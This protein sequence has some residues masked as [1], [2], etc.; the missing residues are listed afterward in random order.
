MRIVVVALAVDPMV[1]IGLRMARVR[2]FG[3]FLER[4]AVEGQGLL[5]PREDV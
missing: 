3:Y 4:Q 5:V 1:R 2:G